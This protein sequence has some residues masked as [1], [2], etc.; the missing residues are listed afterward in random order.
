M[1]NDTYFR[2]FFLFFFSLNLSVTVLLKLL[3]YSYYLDKI[4]YTFVLKD[5]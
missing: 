1:H 2:S 3:I 5:L 4:E